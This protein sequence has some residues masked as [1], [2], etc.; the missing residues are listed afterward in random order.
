MG[1]L[2]RFGDIMR[3]NINDMLDK[4]EDPAKQAEQ[5]LID[6]RKDLVEVKKET[7]AVMANEKAA[8]RKVTDCENEIKRYTVA[9]Q[10]ALRSGNDEDAKTLIAKKQQFESQL[11]EL[12]NNYAVA[13]SNADKMRQMHDKLTSDIEALENKKATI[14]AKVAT[15]KAQQ[16]MNNVSA[17]ANASAG[18]AAFERME[19]KAD[20]MLDAAN[21][22]ADLNADSTSTS[23]LANKYASG[24]SAS[25]EDEFAQMKAELGLGATVGS[26][27]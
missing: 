17:G 2:K 18:I 16:R 21:A 19:D 6:L 1:I 4:L 23:D 27:D 14:K 9:A 5:I 24:C 25:V 26:D 8:A 15:A 3:A 22:E 20:R 7:A 10:N 13:K 12:N 11:T